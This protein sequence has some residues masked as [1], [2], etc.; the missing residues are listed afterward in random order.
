MAEITFIQFYINEATL[1][2]FE[3]LK[4]VTAMGDGTMEKVCVNDHPVTS[5]VSPHV[6]TCNDGTVGKELNIS[7]SGG[8]YLKIQELKVY[9]T[10]TG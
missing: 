9:G 4:V 6:I 7:M 5:P 1:G 3:T 8:L 2:Y 10:I